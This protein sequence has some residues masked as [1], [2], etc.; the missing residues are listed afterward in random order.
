MSGGGMAHFSE[1]PPQ[2]Y[3]KNKND[4]LRW[5]DRKR[6]GIIEENGETL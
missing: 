2:K 1:F 4:R 3:I 5:E 6:L